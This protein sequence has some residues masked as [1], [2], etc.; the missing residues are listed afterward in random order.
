MARLRA[1]DR[2]RMLLELRAPDDRDHQTDSLDP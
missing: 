2:R 1:A